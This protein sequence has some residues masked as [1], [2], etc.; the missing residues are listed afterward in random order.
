VHWLVSR[1]D[2]Q[3]LMAESFGQPLGDCRD[4][5]YWAGCFLAASQA[6]EILLAKALMQLPPHCFGPHSIVA[7]LRMGIERQM[8]GHQR[9]FMA[10]QERY[11]LPFPTNQAGILPFP[12]EAVVNQQQIGPSRHCCLDRPA[13][14]GHRRHYPADRCPPFHL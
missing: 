3:R 2:D 7:K 5:W 6:A 8:V 14:G 4:T 13:T 10:E 9:D 11:T 1:P 12:E